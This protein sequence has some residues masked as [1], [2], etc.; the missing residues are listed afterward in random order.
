MQSAY[1]PS[2]S[3]SKNQPRDVHL[4]RD[5]NPNKLKFTAVSESHGKRN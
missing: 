4:T 3:N 2:I 1:V 5:M